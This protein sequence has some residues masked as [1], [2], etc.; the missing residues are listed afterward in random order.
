MRT[1]ARVS[2]V[3]KAECRISLNDVQVRTPS[4]SAS[5]DCDRGECESW[6]VSWV[7]IANAS[8]KKQDGRCRPGSEAANDAILALK[9]LRQPSFYRGAC[10]SRWGKSEC[11]VGKR[12]VPVRK[13]GSIL[14]ALSS[15]E[16][17]NIFLERTV[18]TNSVLFT[19]CSL[20]S[21]WRTVGTSL[22]EGVGVKYI[23]KL[24]RRGTKEKVAERKKGERLKERKANFGFTFLCSSPSSTRLEAESHSLTLL[25][26]EFQSRGTATVKEDEYE[27]VRWEGMDN[28]EEFVIACLGY[29]GWINFE[30]ETQDSKE[31]RNAICEREE[32]DS[33]FSYD[34]LDGAR[35]TFRGMV[36]RDQPGEYCRRNGRTYYEHVVVSAPRN[37]AF[38]CCYRKALELRVPVALS[39][40]SRVRIG[41][42]LSDPFP[43][44]C[45]VKQGD[46]L[47]PLLFNF[48]LEYAIR[49]VQDNRQGLE[50]NGLHQLLVYADDVNMLKVFENKVLR[51]IFGAKRDEV[52]GEW[53][54][55]HNAELHALYSSPDIIRN[56]KSRRLRW[57]G[58]VARM[59]ESR[60]AYR[61]LVGRPEGK[62]PL[63]RPRRRWE[64]NIKMNLREM[65]YDD[66]DW[67]N[68]AFRIGTDGIMSGWQ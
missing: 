18:L 62:R 57:A 22:V 14:K 20:D 8:A 51:K 24:R 50:L 61:V 60:N 29:D 59:G 9:E 49:K 40:C 53:R 1:T 28:I 67:I 5:G 35:T 6:A 31:W 37:M 42:F 65:G 17:A 64:D 33:G 44:H 66:L 16:N 38:Q 36:L 56:I 27:D 47:S 41:Q 39:D 26:R 19:I 12:T 3:N 34:L 30:N 23:K 21:V 58:H 55:L 54:K 25:G 52:T 13:Y 11:D 48:A 2:T 10:R 46:A 45:G 43:I 7:A 4:Q 15:L 68:L 32:K 63:G